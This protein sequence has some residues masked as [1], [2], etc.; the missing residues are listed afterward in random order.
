MHAALVWLSLCVWAARSYNP[1]QNG[2]KLGEW[3]D[4]SWS[5]NPFMARLDISK[6]GYS[7]ICGGSIVATDGWFGKG[8][9]LTA[10]HCV[11]DAENVNVW[12][13]CSHTNCRDD[14]AKGY[15]DDAYIPH[16]AYDSSLAT[17]DIHWCDNDLALVFL[18]QPITVEGAEA[19]ELHSNISSLHN[20][21]E[22]TVYGYYGSCSG[23]AGCAG[24][25]DTDTLEFATTNYMVADE[26]DNVYGQHVSGGH[27]FCVKDDISAA[28]PWKKGISANIDKRSCGR[29][30]NTQFTNA[31]FVG[32]VRT[33]IPNGSHLHQCLEGHTIT[34]LKRFDIY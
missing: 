6:D 1:K 9:I 24:G 10:A 30:N 23:T 26:C 22:V 2:P 27:D 15:N 25:S 19:V 29:G 31:P 20:D 21:D 33:N 12:I 18:R 16:F 3:T 8:V 7:Y 32:R 28:T 14:L 13:G 34:T 11:D 17:R 4:T 5:D